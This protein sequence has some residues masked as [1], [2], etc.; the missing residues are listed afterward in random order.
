[1]GGSGREVQEGGNIYIY[2]WLICVILQQ[3]S[4]QHCEAIILQFKK[5]KNVLILVFSELQI[6]ASELQI[7]WQDLK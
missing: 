3:K 2:L 7:W 5:E 6:L 1:M 4:R